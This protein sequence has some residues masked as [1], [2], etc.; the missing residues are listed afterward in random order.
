MT[1]DTKFLDFAQNYKIITKKVNKM[2]NNTNDSSIF[3][4]NARMTRFETAKFIISALFDNPQ[5]LLKFVHITG[6]NGKGSVSTMIS[7][8]LMHSGYKTGLFTSPS[9][10]SFMERIKINNIP[11][12]FREYAEIRNKIMS[13]IPLLIK[14]KFNSNKKISEFAITTVAALDHFM[15][16][17]CDIAVLEAGLGGLKDSTNIIESPLVSVI[18]SVSFDHVKRLGSTLE[19]IAFQ[20]SGIIKKGRPVVVSYGQNQC[21]YDVIRKAANQ[22]SSKLIITDPSNIELIS[23]DIKNGT[24][25]RYKGLDINMQLLGKHQIQNALTALTAIDILKTEM[26]IPDDAIQKGM[27]TAFINARLEILSRNPLIILDGAHNEAGIHSLSVFINE[28]LKARRL[29]GIL[30]M[31]KDKNFNNEFS[32]I[33]SLFEE[34]IPTE[35]PRFSRSMPLNKLSSIVK[36]FNKNV[37]PIIDPE[38]AVQ[39]AMSKCTNDCAI[40]IFGSLYLARRILRNQNINK[41]INEML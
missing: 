1:H 8:I 28:Y 10:K 16:N 41:M 5:N 30:G 26:D 36:R 40:I 13:E 18:T 21:V 24:A 11:M 39:Y 6:T 38:K 7:S 20:K 3:N 32:E 33:L 25:F 31:C 27:E 4:S 23:S 2:N 15:R 22:N 37:Q 19:E 12:D 17:N 34:V 29:I 14:N 9:V 35:I